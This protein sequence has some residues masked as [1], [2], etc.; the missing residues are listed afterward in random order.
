MKPRY[1][2]FVKLGHG[3]SSTVWMARDIVED[4]WVAIKICQGSELSAKSREVALLVEI[5]DGCQSEPS[6]DHIVELRDSFI[7]KGP[8][9]LHQCIVT[10]VVAPL[11]DHWVKDKRPFSSARQVA[12]AFSLLHQQGITHG[13]PCLEHLGAALPQ[14]S[15]VDEEQVSCDFPDE[16]LIPVVPRQLGFPMKTVPA[17]AV[18]KD[19]LALFLKQQELLPKYWE[20]QIKVLGFGKG[21]MYSVA[22]GDP[23]STWS[24]EDEHIVRC[25]ELGGPP[26]E[27]W[28]D[29]AK[30]KMDL[31]AGFYSADRDKTWQK[32]AAKPDFQ[33][34]ERQ[35][36]LDLLK[37]MLVSD[38]KGRISMAEVMAHPFCA[39]EW[40]SEKPAPSEEPLVPE[41]EKEATP[42]KLIFGWDDEEE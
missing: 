22:T 39:R 18:R 32:L 26:I 2:I 38:P 15:G 30:P 16:E 8:N 1:R 6:R 34:E 10:E 40:P 14:I 36:L 5:R 12:Q 28:L 20:L 19:S 7:I 13:D 3:E 11:T 23:I 27:A 9:G 37:K 4:R 31:W 25:L 17:Y 29:L 21:N 35:A 42:V 24:H 33:G 41:T